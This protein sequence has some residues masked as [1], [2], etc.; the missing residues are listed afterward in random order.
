[1]K[2]SQQYKDEVISFYNMYGWT[3]TRDKYPISRN[4][5]REWLNPELAKANNARCI[6]YK[7]NRYK[8]DHNFAKKYSQDVASWAKDRKQNDPEWKDICNKRTHQCEIDR[9]LIDIDYKEQLKLRRKI[10]RRNR[11]SKIK[12]LNELYTY[13]DRKYTFNLFNNKCA[14]CESENDLHLDHWMPL[15]KGFIL[16]RSNAVLLC[17]RCNLR[18]GNKLPQDFF[19]NDVFS[20]I[21]SKL[22]IGV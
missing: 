14:Y 13:D 15:S 16:S 7:V 18:K 10:N 11:K 4:T 12:D 21:Q 19:P 8:T 22:N 2:Y 5:F 1:M 3:I 20:R 9:C 6:K 17:R